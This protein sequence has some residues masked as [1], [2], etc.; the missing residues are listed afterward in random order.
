MERAEYRSYPPVVLVTDQTH[1]HA[2]V[3]AAVHAVDGTLITLGDLAHADSPLRHTLTVSGGPPPL[4]LIDV[5]PM[6][7]SGHPTLVDGWALMAVVMQ[8]MLAGEVAPALLIGIGDQLRDDTIDCTLAAGAWAVLET[9]QLAAHRETLAASAQ[10][11][12]LLVRHLAAHR[13]AATQEDAAPHAQHWRVIKALG[14]RLY[15]GLQTLIADQRGNDVPVIVP[16]TPEDV[17]I[18][19]EYNHREERS[20]VF[21]QLGGEAFVQPRLDAALERVRINPKRPNDQLIR[22]LQRKIKKGA[23]AN[24]LAVSRATCYRYERWLY[25]D[26]AHHYNQLAG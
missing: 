3:H 6:T 1:V 11:S 21:Q 24:H 23:I 26:I 17:A 22:F 25:R 2:R 19:L 9:S 10:D 7:V 20:Q 15:T 4:I 14:V 5:Q 8:W 16:M 13:A 12:A 18:L